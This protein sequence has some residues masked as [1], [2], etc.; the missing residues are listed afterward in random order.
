MITFFISYY[1]KS[2]LTNT[3]PNFKDKVINKVIS[4]TGTPADDINNIFVKPPMATK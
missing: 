2:N 3:L 1:T 4:P